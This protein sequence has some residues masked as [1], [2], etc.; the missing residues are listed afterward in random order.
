MCAR[1]WNEP[2]VWEDEPFDLGGRLA[3]GNVNAAVRHVACG[4]AQRD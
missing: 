1:L 3:A 4:K 2:L